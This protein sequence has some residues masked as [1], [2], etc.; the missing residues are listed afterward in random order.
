MPHLHEGLI[1]A[2]HW[3]RT[4]V[5]QAQT[6]FLHAHWNAQGHIWNEHTL[7]IA[8]TQESTTLLRL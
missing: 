8:G 2:G 7:H 3:H 5:G 6:R 4:G 1:H